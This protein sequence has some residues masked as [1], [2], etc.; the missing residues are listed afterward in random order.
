[1]ADT[2]EITGNT[3]S[4]RDQLKALGC[5]WLASRKVWVAPTDDVAA[6]AKALVPAGR[7]AARRT[8]NA[9]QQCGCK[10]NYGKYCGKCEFGR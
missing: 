7:G 8:G 4:V 1:M 5:I 2:L 3:Y 6:K 9:C 10:I